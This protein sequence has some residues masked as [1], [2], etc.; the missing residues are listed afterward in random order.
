MI[1][2]V[3]ADTYGQDEPLQRETVKV[4]DQEIRKRP[5]KSI[6]LASAAGDVKQV[7]LLI[8]SGADIKNIC[9]EAGMFAIRSERDHVINDD[10]IDSIKKITGEKETTA[11][12]TTGFI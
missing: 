7:R 9:T 3:I 4:E 12:H 2:I 11:K 8:S 6:H 10:F 1:L 5:S